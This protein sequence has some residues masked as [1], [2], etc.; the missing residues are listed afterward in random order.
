MALKETPWFYHPDLTA[1]YLLPDEARHAGSALRLA[2]EDKVILTTGRGEIATATIADVSKGKIGVTIGQVS[3]FPKPPVEKTLVVGRMHHAD[4]LEWLVE[5][6]QELGLARLL[7]AE[8]ERSGAGRLNLERTERIAISALKQSHQP[9]LCKIDFAASLEKALG[10][11]FG[12]GLFGYLP[13]GGD[14]PVSIRHYSDASYVIIGPEAD[15]S[16]A[17]VALMQSL[18]LKPVSLGGT[19]L[20]TETAALAAAVHLML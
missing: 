16:L 10:S 14:P 7:I 4:R 9:W 12:L 2:R 19:R 11:C 6:C 15:F 8:T 17:E 3:T 18:G 5:K 13:E 20:R 1:G